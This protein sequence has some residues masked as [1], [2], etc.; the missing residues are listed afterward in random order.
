[1][2]PL[3]LPVAPT[4]AADSGDHPLEFER[5]WLGFMTARATLGGVLV[6]FQ[7][8]VLALVPQSSSALL[9]ICMAYFAATL[10]VRLKTHPQQLRPALDA[11]WL[12][13]V[14]VDV[15]TFV[16]LQMVQGGAI[17][18][19]P[20][21]ALP[22]LM[23]SV[24]GSM[25]LAMATAA[26]ITLLLFAH[27]LWLLFQH[28]GD[29]GAF[30]LQSAL[31]G[32]GC[33]AIAFISNQL[34]T[35]LANMELRAQRNQMAATEQRQVNELV[36]Q[37]LTEGVMVVDQRGKVRSANPAACLLLNTQAPTSE[38][39]LSRQ[40]GTQALLHLI[41]TSFA[42]QTPQQA[43]ISLHLPE[44]SRRKVRVRTQLT[45]ASPGGVM[46]LCVVFMEDQREIQARIRS[47]KLAGMGRMSA[48]VAH[49]IRNPLAAITQANALLAEDL[50][51]P[52]QQRLAKMVG[53]NALRLENIVKDVLHLTHAGT[54]D[55]D[56]PAQPLDLCENTQR[57]CRDW[58]S[59]QAAANPLVMNLTADV[60]KVWFDPEHLRRVLINLLDNALRY[61][62]QQPGSIQVSLGLTESGSPQR[63]VTLRVWSD[64]AVLDASMEQHLFEPFF[65]SE[66]RSSGLG[67][68]ICRELCESHGA[69]ISYERS[70]RQMA[71]QPHPGNEFSVNFKLAP[72]KYPTP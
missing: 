60:P 66:S 38:L 20:L 41:Q 35:R 56:D 68:Y 31:T 29:A 40:S 8:S 6:V 13:I 50:R 72:S 22:V 34:A 62:S 28:A 51:E 46:G 71:D 58:R 27:A 5:L 10:T 54:S 19:T 18:Y 43:D 7:G 25:L 33:F 3:W 42:S 67:L 45:S 47:E 69:S 37:S 53:Q 23:V 52:A 61:A 55:P 70:E 44:H 14:G 49:E 39:D 65:S 26:C 16:I 12:R 21:F 17:N 32:A 30:F 9:W 4:A 36:I 24:L 63:G 11:Q 57:I 15:L 59:Q 48:A 64:G 1:V 2:T